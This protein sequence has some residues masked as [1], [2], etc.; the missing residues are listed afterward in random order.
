ML[1]SLWGLIFSLSF[2][3]FGQELVFSLAPTSFPLLSLS[4]HI[5]LL[6]GFF[7]FIISLISIFCSLYGLGYLTHFYKK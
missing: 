2:I 1:A 3:L 4:F 5:D 7:V 6:A